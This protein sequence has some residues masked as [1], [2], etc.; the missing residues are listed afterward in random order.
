[1]KHEPLYF[2]GSVDSHAHLS[3]AAKKGLDPNRIVA[4]AT[5]GGMACIVDVGVEPSDLDERI[6]RY[7]GTPLVAFTSG[8]HPTNV[9][10]DDL[11]R[12]TAMLAQALAG[13]RVVAVGETG[14][15]FYWSEEHRGL[16]IEALE[17][18]A[19]LARRHDRAL[20]LHNRSSED[21]M[22]AF[23]KRVR[24]RGVMHCFSQGADYC[25][26]CLDLGMH[27]SFGGNMTYPKSAPLREAAA[28]VPDDR[29][30]VETDS[31]F[32][33]PQAV[34]G[35]VNHPGHLGYVIT[36]LAEVRGQPPGR[37]A[38]LTSANARRL[39]ALSS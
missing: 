27:I 6:A 9:R 14:L 39:F 21:E 11:D 30:L 7:G 37:V 19:E 20:I 31:P 16:Q 17:A 2:P 5:S 34:R 4:A 12:Q 3:I 29:L 1:M 22:L 28:I 24:P 18:Q 10:P 38:E 13:G 26:S 8:L 23:L 15:D 25:R 35:S 32:L 33:S 36:A